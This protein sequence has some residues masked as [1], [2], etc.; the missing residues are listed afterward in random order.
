MASLFEEELSAKHP[1][2]GHLWMIDGKTVDG[3]N[4]DVI[5]ITDTR[6][7]KGF[8]TPEQFPNLEWL[9]TLGGIPNSTGCFSNVTTLSCEKIT[10]EDIE[11]LAQFPKLKTFVCT[12]DY[13]DRNA[14][15]Q[16]LTEWKIKTGR[17][18][19]VVIH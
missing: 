12:P 1:D 11:R 8:I 10:V 2:D 19:E 6:G 13:Y 4:P 16:A 18:F 14:I 9:T 3:E 7:S 17:T 5:E 15:K